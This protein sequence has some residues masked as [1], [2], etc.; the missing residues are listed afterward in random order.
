MVVPPTGPPTGPPRPGGGSGGAPSASRSGTAGAARR[1]RFWTGDQATAL[2]RAVDRLLDVR[3][4]T[5]EGTLYRAMYEK[6]LNPADGSPPEPLFYR[7]SLAGRRYSPRK[8]PAGLYLSYDPST[9]PAELRLVVFEHG[10]PVSTEEH[11]PIVTI[12]V[13][14]TVHHMLDVTDADVRRVLSITAADLRAD[15]ETEQDGYLA[16]HGPMP[17]TQLLALA[18]HTS[19]VVTGIK[20]PSARTRFG[21][22]LVVFP[23]RLDATLADGLEVVDSTNRYRQRLP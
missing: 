10:F 19:G 22:N 12:A 23:D 11:D 21:N 8:G 1:T 6:Y 9:P 5:V 7:G 16:G 17:V 3:L 13:R 20:Y 18:A 4:I 2:T 15:W 14:A